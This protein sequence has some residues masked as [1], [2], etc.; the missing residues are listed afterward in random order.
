MKCTEFHD[1]L[2]DY[3]RGLLSPDMADQVSAHL[4]KCPACAEEYRSHKSL[5]TLLESEPEMRIDSNEL[6]DFL[7]G[8]WNKIENTRRKPSKGWLYKL[9]PALAAAALLAFI[10]LKPTIETPVQI[11][12]TGE[13][14][15]TIDTD[16][17]DELGYKYTD[18]DIYSE[19]NYESLISLL[20]AD[21][22]SETLESIESEL[23]YE[24]SM[25]SDY[26]YSLDNLSNETIE[27][28][29]EKLNELYN[30]AG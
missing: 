3:I 18:T 26:G 8:V 27:L 7:P 23:S 29:D 10:M 16:Y 15:I 28:M 17:Y 6:A 13:Q 4:D 1:R 14:E 21:Y 30:H 5:L 25:F 19:S 2:D 9:V 22:S 20:F 12:D 24:T 11:A